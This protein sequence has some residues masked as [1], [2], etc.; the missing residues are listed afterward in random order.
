[1]NSQ[2]IERLEIF[3][4]QQL[5]ENS[6]LFDLKA[7]IDN[8]LTYE[9]NKNIIEDKISGLKEFNP[10][11]EVNRDL[12][13]QMKES[14]EDKP[15]ITTNW[16]YQKNKK[17]K[18][19]FLKPQ[20]IALVGNVNE[21][22]SN[23]LYFLIEELSKIG[24]F[25]LYTYGLRNK[26]KIAQEIN[27]VAEMEKIKNSI[28]I[29]DELFSLFDLENRKVKTQIESTLRLINH[30]NNILVL[31]GVGENFK[32]FLSAKINVFIYKSVNFEDLINGSK[33]KNVIMNYKGSES[34]TTLLNLS[35]NEAIIYDGLHYQKMLI[36]YLVKYDSKVKNKSIIQECTK[37]RSGKMKK[38][39]PN[40]GGEIRWK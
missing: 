14:S 12:I 1:M 16:N 5:K 31:C 32:K 6:D 4:M 8:T 26:I 20:I 15:K 28:I 11:E 23:V 10:L 7:E 2:E 24:K 22:K 30:N 29:I 3:V 33:V 37:K 35:K 21:G 40:Q 9:E 19:M 13:R 25:N 18:E 34:G 27:S 38:S 17:I 36:P 39:V